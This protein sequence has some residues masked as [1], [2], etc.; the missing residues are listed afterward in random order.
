MF[1]KERCFYYITAAFEIK[2]FIAKNI[3]LHNYIY[4]LYLDYLFFIVSTNAGG[5]FLI[6]N[7]I[8]FILKYFKKTF[9]L[10]NVY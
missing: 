1:Y 10:S 9:F 8:L 4:S 6:S 3:S 2:R 5:K 7:V